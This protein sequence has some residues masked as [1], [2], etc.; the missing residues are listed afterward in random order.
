M[1]KI[2]ALVLALAMVFGLV[3]CATTAKVE[4]A[5]KAEAAA[6]AA[7]PA[8]VEEPAK[9][10]EPVAAQ[11][12]P[13]EP[14]PELTEIETKTVY[15]TSK[16]ATMTAEELYE[17]A[18]AEGGT[19]VVYSETGSTEKAVP[20]FQ[21]KYP[22]IAVEATKY[23]NYLIAEKI[24]LEVESKQIYAD[25]IVASDTTGEKYYEWYDK[26]YIE[27]YIPAD[28]KDDL[29]A[30]YLTF[31]LPITIEGYVWYY[32]TAMYPDGC[33]ITNWWDIIE[34]DE[35]GNSKYHL[36]VNSIDSYLANW[37][38]LVSN[39]DSLLAAY[40]EKYGT[41]LEFTYDAD[42]LGVEPNNAGY[43]WIYRFLQTN[44]DI[45]TSGGEL[46]ATVDAATEP[47]LCLA[48]SLLLGDAQEAGE[49][50]MYATKL[51]PFGGDAAVKNIYMIPGSDNPAA[52]RL[53]AIYILGDVDGQ[54]EGYDKFVA[55]NGCYGVRYS[56]DD[57]TH[58]EVPLKDVGL[59]Q[60]NAGYIYENMQYVNDFW[61]FYAD[62]FAK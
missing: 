44:W 42:E 20:G 24:P 21:E 37:T 23:K 41:D 10:A 28:L 58:S 30:D 27:T 7:E 54:G 56:H 4:E 62:K 8:K 35:N 47:T 61:T 55:R 17:A 57:S 19:L 32:S 50:V 38:N 15:D 12:K 43:E 51:V 11:E 1:K 3:A 14:A 34:L 49:N 26:G 45:I 5:P 59:V 6:P 29:Y 9:A 36:Y 16:Y 52:A 53:F 2:L 31:G 22:G 46:V 39:S 40:K 13:A 18:K 33:P 48:S 25:M 60:M